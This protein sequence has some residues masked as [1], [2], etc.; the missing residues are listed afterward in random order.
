MRKQQQWSVVSGQC[1]L[2]ARRVLGSPGLL[3]QEAEPRK[4]EPDCEGEGLY[5]SDR[6]G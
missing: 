2:E 4:A 5:D 1:L 6:P 3:R